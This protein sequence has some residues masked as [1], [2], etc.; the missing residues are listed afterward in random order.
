MKIEI[1]FCFLLYPN[2]LAP[3]KK[4]TIIYYQFEN[5]RVFVKITI[6]VVYKTTK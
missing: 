4:E 5:F 3:D 6:S 2:I 1:F